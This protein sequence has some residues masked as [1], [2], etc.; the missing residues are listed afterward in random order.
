MT[1]IHIGLSTIHIGLPTLPISHWYE[2]EENAMCMSQ[3]PIPK[4]PI[5]IGFPTLHISHWYEVED[6]GMCM[7][8][9][10]ILK[11]PIHIGLPT[12][13][14]SHDNCMTHGVVFPQESAVANNQ[15]QLGK[16]TIVQ[17]KNKLKKENIL[18]DSEK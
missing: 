12:L 14:I 11:I 8:Q 16:L 10:P 5:H 13:P 1:H 3:N 15:Q 6:G 4:I 18:K 7:S 17:L 9:N 2:V